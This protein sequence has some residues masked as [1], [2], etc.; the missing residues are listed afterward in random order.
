[1]QDIGTIPGEVA[2]LAI[3]VNDAGVI[4]RI[5]VDSSFNPRAFVLTQWNS[6]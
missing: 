2:S 4:V 3:S 1:M 5:S 6:H